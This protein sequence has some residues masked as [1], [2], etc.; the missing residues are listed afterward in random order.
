MSCGGR[1]SE[2]QRVEKLLE[3]AK[4]FDDFLSNGGAQGAPGMHHSH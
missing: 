3:D 2:K 1:T 4:A